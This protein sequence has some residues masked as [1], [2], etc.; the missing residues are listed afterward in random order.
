[1]QVAIERFDP[2]RHDSA[3]VARLI[4]QADPSLMRFVL[5]A[6]DEAV[7]VLTALVEM[8][9]NDYSGRYVR[10]AVD[11]TGEVV[12]IAAGLTGAERRAATRLRGR[13]WGRA[14]GARRMLRAMRWGSKLE[15]V[16]TTEVADDE[17]YLS[18]LTVDERHRGGGVGSALLSSVTAEHPVVI[19]DVNITKNDALRFYRRHGF[20][21]EREMTFVH[22]GDA[23]GNFQIR[24]DAR[25]AGAG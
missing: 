8:E 5:G 18:A 22:K 21:V 11:E 4:Y 7:P 24:R 20:E 23:L 9:H 2:A 12:G 13:E 25:A 17:F 15:S 3:T 6:E 14:L 1:M 19:T 10:C 16:A